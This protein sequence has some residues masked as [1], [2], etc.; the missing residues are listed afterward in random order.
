MP[1]WWCPSARCGALMGG[2]GGSSWTVILTG[3]SSMAKHWHRVTATLM[4][5]DGCHVASPVPPWCWFPILCPSSAER[6]NTG[7][8]EM[9]WSYIRAAELQGKWLFVLLK[10]CN[11]E[12]WALEAQLRT[13]EG[14][15]YAQH[16]GKQAINEKG[17]W[18]HK[19]HWGLWR[20]LT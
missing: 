5:M 7:G 14:T 12:S 13:I 11:G 2:K 3:R 20:K 1:V 6:Q 18:F 10:S 19:T 8:T 4:D 15:L 16:V 17:V 9:W